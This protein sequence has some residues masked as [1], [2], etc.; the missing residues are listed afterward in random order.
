MITPLGRGAGICKGTEIESGDSSEKRRAR[1]GGGRWAWKDKQWKPS[2]G[3]P[4]MPG[5]RVL[6]YIL[7]GAGAIAGSWGR[8]WWDQHGVERGPYAV[9]RKD[10]RDHKRHFSRSGCKPTG[11]GQKRGMKIRFRCYW[12]EEDINSPFTAL[13]LYFFSHGSHI[14]KPSWMFQASLNITPPSPS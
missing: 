4:W 13:I 2:H 11:T 9:W 12:E 3:G 5:R 14:P 10:L 1:E 8:E 7:G 6:K